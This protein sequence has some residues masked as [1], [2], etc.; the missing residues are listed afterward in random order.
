[1]SRPATSCRFVLPLLLAAWLAGCATGGRLQTAGSLEA[2]GL[3]MENSL[4]WARYAGRRQ[5]TWTIDGV[6][7][8]RLHIL[9]GI[10]PGEHVFQTGRERRNRPQGPWFHPGMRPDDQQEL[11]LAAL[12]EQG[13]QAVE[14]SNLR[15]ARFGNLDGLRF[16]FRLV[17]ARGLRYGGTAAMLERNDRLTVAY[18]MAPLEH[19]HDRDAAAVAALLDG[20]TPIE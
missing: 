14:A 18:W 10:Q 11:L 7:L 8:N 16:E 19:Y 2:L 13:W 6:A 3:R 1:M 17:S 5:E 4:D 9:A 12:R 15:P 20:L